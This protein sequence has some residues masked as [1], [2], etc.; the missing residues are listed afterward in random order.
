MWEAVNGLAVALLAQGHI[1]EAIE[2]LEEVLHATPATV[3]AA[4]PFLFNLCE[5]A[6]MAIQ[7]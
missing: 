6:P 5:C 7:G 4:E 1:S 3:T 2:V